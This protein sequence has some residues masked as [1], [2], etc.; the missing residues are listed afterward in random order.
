M[1]HSQKT[2]QYINTLLVSLAKKGYN[3]WSHPL[4]GEIYFEYN[5]SFAGTPTL[6]GIIT[7]DTKVSQVDKL[8]KDLEELNS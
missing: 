1:I 3:A 2:F 5:V 7:G 6:N 8:I 4:E